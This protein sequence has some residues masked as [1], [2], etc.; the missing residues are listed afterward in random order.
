MKEWK[1]FI[2]TSNSLEGS[3]SSEI[4]QCTKLTK[5]YLYN[6]SL[7]GFIPTEVGVLTKLKYLDISS[8]YLNGTMPGFVC[9]E[10]TSDFNVN[11]KIFAISAKHSIVNF[12]LVVS[13]LFVC[14]IL[15]FN[16]PIQLSTLYTSVQR[17]T[18]KHMRTSTTKIK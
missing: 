4:G 16:I 9:N 15:V 6:N 3:I 13:C 7:D 8:N 14:L 5:L 11:P 18:S 17:K 10:E 2:I 12:K 1:E